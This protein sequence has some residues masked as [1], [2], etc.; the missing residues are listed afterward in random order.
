MYIFYRVLLSGN[1]SGVQQNLKRRPLTPARFLCLS[2]LPPLTPLSVPSFSDSIHLSR[3]PSPSVSNYVVSL[4]FSLSSPGPCP[5]YSSL[6]AVLFPPLSVCLSQFFCSLS[7]SFSLNPRSHTLSLYL[8]CSVN[9]TPHAFV[10]GEQKQSLTFEPYSE[11]VSKK[12]KQK[13]K[14]DHLIIR[15]AM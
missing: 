6:P 13:R 10:A 5:L 14:P 11:E 9:V 15:S 12:T 3:S 1:I 8:W 2:C 7:R 4:S